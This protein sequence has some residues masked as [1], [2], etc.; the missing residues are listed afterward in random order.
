MFVIYIV[1]F[2]YYWK[3]FIDGVVL[4]QWIDLI[5]D[6]AMLK[7]GRAFVSTLLTSELEACVRFAWR[8]NLIS[9]PR[10]LTGA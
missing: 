10:L 8:W 3:I 6:L 2:I 7:A 4:Q 5:R 9:L 1:L